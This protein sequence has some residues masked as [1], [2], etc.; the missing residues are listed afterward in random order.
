MTNTIVV[1]HNFTTNTS[2]DDVLRKQLRQPLYFP[3]SV[4]LNLEQQKQLHEWYT[5]LKQN[6]ILLF[7]A[8]R[9]GF[10]ASDFHKHCD[11]F[12]ETITIIRTPNKCIFGG[13]SPLSWGMNC[14]Y[15]TNTDAWIFSLV[16][17]H[18]DEP[19]QMFNSGP[20]FVGEYSLSIYSHQ[21][22]TFGGGYDIHLSDSF[23][24][25]DHNYTNLHFSYAIPTSDDPSISDTKFAQEYLCGSYHYV[26]EEVEVYGAK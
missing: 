6:W 19:V 14:G 4:I 9:D 26:A 20:Q 17:P 16:R 3:Q 18:S 2:I 1:L 15:I 7:R 24:N 13:Y 21:G 10:T 22:P 5:G 11:N 25:N 8:S 23:N 12:Q